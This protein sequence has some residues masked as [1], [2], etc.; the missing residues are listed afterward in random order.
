VTSTGTARRFI[1][2]FEVSGHRV[3]ADILMQPAES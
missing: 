2:F 1:Y 3:V